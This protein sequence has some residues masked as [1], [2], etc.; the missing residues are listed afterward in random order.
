F[1]NHW[2][3]PLSLARMPSDTAYGIF[4]VGMNHAGEIE[5][6]SRLIRPHVAIVTTVEAAHLEYFDSVAA[7]ADAKAEIFTGVEPDGT[8]VLYRDNLHFERLEAA[9]RRSNQAKQGSPECLTLTAL[10]VVH[11]PP[12]RRGSNYL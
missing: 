3:V 11:E 7:I 4:E 1:N 2:G 8:A 12:W 6:L 10:A 5:P 9:A